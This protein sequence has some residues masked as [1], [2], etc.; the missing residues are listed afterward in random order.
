MAQTREISKEDR[1]RIVA[2]HE[3][4]FS[5]ADIPRRL[6]YHGISRHGMQ[7]TRQRFA[8]T[9][10]YDNRQ[11]QGRPRETCNR[12]DRE[13]VRM[14]LRNRRANSTQLTTEWNSIRGTNL[15]PSTIRLKLLQ[16]GLCR[17]VAK[18]KPLISK[19]NKK[20]RLR[21]AREHIHWGEEELAKVL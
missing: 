14:S 10:S 12:G 5:Q 18:K 7:T 9:S 21:F 16:V 8:A 13:I 3:V 11:R 2:L 4:G 15:N 1:M 19:L 17:C 6:K 20:K